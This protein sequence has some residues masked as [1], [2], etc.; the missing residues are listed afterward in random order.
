[1]HKTSILSSS[2]KPL[3]RNFSSRNVI[4]PA[5]C[6]DIDYERILDRGGTVLHPTA[7]NESVSRA[8]FERFPLG[9]HFQMPPHNVD[10][11]IVRMAVHRSCPPF[12]HLV[13][14]EKELVVISQHAACQARFRMGFF[15]LVTR[16]DHKVGI[17]FA[18]RF[19]FVPLVQGASAVRSDL[20]A[21]G[22]LASFTSWAYRIAKLLINSGFRS[23][24]ACFKINSPPTPNAAAP[25]RM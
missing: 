1:M 24:I 20:A 3:E 4:F 21:V 7:D 2:G 5:R 10:D 19:H 9:V 16:R 13:L 23:S 18:L 12:H 11:L 15:G 17:S 8:Q 25:A 6:E 22:F 14:D